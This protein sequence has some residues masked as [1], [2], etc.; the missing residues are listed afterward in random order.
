M[1]LPLLAAIGAH[2]A[3]SSRDGNEDA[4][5][6]RQQNA[7]PERV[8]PRARAFVAPFQQPNLYNTSGGTQ[9]GNFFMGP[10]EI[11]HGPAVDIRAGPLNHGGR[12]D[13][14]RT[15]PDAPGYGAEGNRPLEALYV[16]ATPEDIAARQSGLNALYNPDLPNTGRNNSVQN[17]RIYWANSVNMF[18]P[19][20]SVTILPAGQ[21][22]PQNYPQQRDT[23]LGPFQPPRQVISQ[24]FRSLNNKTYKVLDQRT[25]RATPVMRLDKHVDR[26]PLGYSAPFIF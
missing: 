15:G 8:G 9:F 10:R 26:S 2:L 5:T 16:H 6:A 18:R 24:G 14:N 25:G 1:A 20:A 11:I 23:V 12:W 4:P 3:A 7:P 13:L 17:R 19:G 22:V 21:Y